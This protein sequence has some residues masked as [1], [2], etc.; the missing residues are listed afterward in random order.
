MREIF[1]SERVQCHSWNSLWSSMAKVIN[2]PFFFNLHR[3]TQLCEWKAPLSLKELHKA[4][5]ELSLNSLK[6]TK[7]K[8]C[9]MCVH[10]HASALNQYVLKNM[11][12]QFIRSFS[13]IIQ[14]LVLCCYGRCSHEI[15][16]EISIGVFS[17]NEDLK[18]DEW[19]RNVISLSLFSLSWAMTLWRLPHERF[20]WLLTDVMHYQESLRKQNTQSFNVSRI[21]RKWCIFRL[22]LKRIFVCSHLFIND[23]P[24]HLQTSD[25]REFIPLSCWSPVENWFGFRFI[26]LSRLLYSQFIQFRKHFSDKANIELATKIID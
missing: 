22:T 1:S 25:P 23:A 15:T 3:L 8:W 10:Q 7:R 4:N 5:R 9:I 11:F 13:W 2:L 24:D 12:K 26:P 21:M 20:S 16:W 18:W 6:T 19:G 17:V 14:W